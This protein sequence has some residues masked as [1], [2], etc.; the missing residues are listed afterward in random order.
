MI[1]KRKTYCNNC[2]HETRIYCREQEVG[3]GRQEKHQ[4]KIKKKKG[5]MKQMEEKN[6]T[7]SVIKGTLE[8][9][10]MTIGTSEDKEK[11]KK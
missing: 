8:K 5:L 1:L 7:I 3:K 9:A 6:K 4:N 11:A 2:L 10:L